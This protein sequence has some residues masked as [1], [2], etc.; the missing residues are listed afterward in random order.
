MQMAATR[1]CR[2]THRYVPLPAFLTGTTIR[3]LSQARLRQLPIPLPP[4][5][6]QQKVLAQVSRQFSLAQH[7]ETAGAGVVGHA[8]ALRR[9]V[10]GAAFAGRLQTRTTGALSLDNV[11]EDVA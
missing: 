4:V 5:H 9:S 1:S 7:L 2:I 6:V 10:L 8:R 3:H 11:E